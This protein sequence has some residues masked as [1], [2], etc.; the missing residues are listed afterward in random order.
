MNLR[1]EDYVFCEQTTNI[2]KHEFKLFYSND[3]T[4]YKSSDMVCWITICCIAVLLSIHLVTHV[5]VPESIY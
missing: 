5:F 4:K 1:T 3:T 2:G